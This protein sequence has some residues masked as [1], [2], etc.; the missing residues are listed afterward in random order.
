MQEF[1]YSLEAYGLTAPKIFRNLPPAK[2][3]EEAILYDPG[4][5]IADSGALASYSGRKTGRSPLDK[6]VVRHPDSEEEIWWG[7]VNVPLDPHAFLVNRE[8]ALDYLNTRPRL[9]VVDGFAGW[10]PAYR[11]KVRIVTSR[12]YHA[13]FMTNMLIRPSEEG[14]RTFGEPTWTVFNAGAFPANRHTTGMTSK[15]SLDLNLESR[16]FVIL[17][18]EYA[19]EMK[20]AVFTLMNWLMPARGALSMHAAATEDPKSGSV[21]VL[22]GLSGTGKTSLGI[23]PTRLLIGDDEIVWSEEGVFNI[24]GGCYAATGQLSLAEEPEIA[25]SLRFG[26]L[27]ENVLFEPR[28]RRVDWQNT[29]ITVNT[30]GAFPI[31]FL[32]TAKLPCRGHHPDQ[33]IFLTCDAYGVLPPVAKLT[34]EEAIYHFLAG[35][36]AKVGGTEDGVTVPQATF[37]PC[38]GAPFLLLPPRNYATLFAEKL[39]AHDCDVWM[40][41][42][43]WFG[44][45]VGKGRRF[46]LAES[47]AMLH[48]IYS[49]EL[50]D[51]PTEPLDRFRMSRVTNI[52]GFPESTCDPRRCWPDPEPY[53]RAAAQLAD[54]FDKHMESYAHDVAAVAKLLPTRA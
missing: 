11:L 12:P 14:L 16:E 6:R 45:P 41:N 30:R 29:S 36:T 38:F 51:A 49:G 43:G 33:I 20:K 54:R 39:A 50:D 47:R 27:L 44:G 21:A 10:D 17:G 19:G 4:A 24:E 15:T 3:Y 31:D 42:T 13:L 26:A 35:Y 8:R 48:A 22:F 32:S 40:L 1:E 23:D 5:A 2:L 7:P 46:T 53:D 25:A 37:S 52:P 28:T 18:T 34:H 9:Y